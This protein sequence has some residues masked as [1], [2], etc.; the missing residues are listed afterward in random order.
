MKIEVI[1]IAGFASAL[2]ALHLPFGGKEKSE[3]DAY[4]IRIAMFSIP[5]YCLP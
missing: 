1:E 3:I 5:L 2:K 4:Y